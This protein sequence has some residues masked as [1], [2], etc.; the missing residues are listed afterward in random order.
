[1]IQKTF[2]LISLFIFLF[3][4]QSYGQTERDTVYFKLQSKMI[5]RARVGQSNI[6]KSDYFIY[7]DLKKEYHSKY[8]QL[9]GK[10][11]GNYLGIS[12]EADIISPS[13]PVITAKITGGDVTIGI[14]KKEK[15]AKKVLQ[16]I[17]NNNK[18]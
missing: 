13:L 7:V 6:E 1:M 17:L 18:Q 10:N 11:I 5:A 8:S 14:F 9:T 2:I 15:N 3:P 16:K 12:F 4:W